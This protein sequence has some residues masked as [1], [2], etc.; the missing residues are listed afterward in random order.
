MSSS[1]AGAFLL[2]PSGQQ[3]GSVMQF[4]DFF[5]DT[6]AAEVRVYI[7]SSLEV[8]MLMLPSLQR[9]VGFIDPS[10]HKTMPGWPLRN[11]LT[12]LNVRF[13]VEEIRVLCWKSGA[14][15]ASD[16]SVLVE[17]ES[18]KASTVEGCVSSRGSECLL[19]HG[20]SKANQLIYIVCR[21]SLS[22]LSSKRHH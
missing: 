8:R 4:I 19:K 12:L 7:Y 22:F 17:L 3:L 13:N 11:L 6:P 9:I 15:G 18:V 5:K 21:T 10:P 2:R 1:F 20:I 14:K 16:R